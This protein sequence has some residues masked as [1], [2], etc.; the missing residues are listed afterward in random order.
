MSNSFPSH[1]DRDMHSIS[2]R[3][4]ISDDA[5]LQHVTHTLQCYIEHHTPART[6]LCHETPTGHVW[7]VRTV[8]KGLC[9]TNRS[10]YIGKLF[11]AS[12]NIN[13][14][15]AKEHLTEEIVLKYTNDPCTR[16]MSYGDYRSTMIWDFD[17]LSGE[18][19]TK[20]KCRRGFLQR[21]CLSSH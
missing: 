12:I 3:N 15:R 21:K 10:C 17:P 7:H 1:L 16:A 5:K 8:E 11:M 4:D 6:P 9:G 20:W 19:K 13:A 18:I 2:P 14:V